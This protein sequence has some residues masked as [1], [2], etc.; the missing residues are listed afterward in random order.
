M[1]GGLRVAKGRRGEGARGS[2]SCQAGQSRCGVSMCSS[3]SAN[4]RPRLQKGPNGNGADRWG[5]RAC[6][7]CSARRRAAAAWGVTHDC[8][9]RPVGRSKITPSLAL[10]PGGETNS[11]RESRCPGRTG[12]ETRASRWPC[13]EK[14]SSSGSG[15][16]WDWL[17]RRA[18][19]CCCGQ[20]KR[21]NPIPEKRGKKGSAAVAKA[22][23][24]RQP[25]LCE[26]IQGQLMISPKI[27]A[28]VAS[29]CPDH[30]RDPT[31]ARFLFRDLLN[32]L[33]ELFRLEACRADGC[34]C[35]SKAPKR[36]RVGAEAEA[37]LTAVGQSGATLARHTPAPA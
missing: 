32:F 19:L 25:I 22:E 4:V 33:L 18:L 36:V 15:A 13:L 31:D 7:R 26:A 29:C 6:V 34:V 11:W 1:V 20:A 16:N 37:Q 3:L 12:Q 8:D 21:R 28:W 24:A 27:S 9:C 5:V 23:S 2:R 10:L 30:T 35:V 17:T 14:G